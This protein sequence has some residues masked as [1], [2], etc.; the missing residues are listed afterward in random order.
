MGSAAARIG[1]MFSPFIL[2]I[3]NSLPWFTQVI[4]LN[5]YVLGAVFVIVAGGAR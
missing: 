1:S 3:N 5:I 4:T 2:L